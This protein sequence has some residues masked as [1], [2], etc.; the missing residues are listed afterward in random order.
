MTWLSSRWKI[1]IMVIPALVLFTAFIAYP[2]LYS[3]VFSFTRFNGFK[4]PV[5]NGGANY[6]SLFQDSYF[7]RS[8]GNTAIIFAITLVVLIPLAFLLALLMQ[9]RIPGAGGLRALVFAPAIIAPILSG[10]IWIF[11][12]DPHVGLLNQVLGALNLPRPE[13]IGGT[14]LTPFSVAWVYVWSQL[15]FA[16]TIFYAGLQLVP[17]D[18]LE[19]SELDGANGVKR[20]WYVIIPMIRETF[21]IITVLMITGVFKVFEIVYVLTGGGPT[22]TSET[23]VSYVYFLTFTSQRYGLGMAGA[24]IVTILGMVVGL[25]Y[26]VVA[27]RRQ[28]A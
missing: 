1:A 15:G 23:L 10:L 17:S 28:S 4:P 26:L 24:V 14:T 7:W 5:F 19:A 11:I 16:M 18:I 8:L 2:V 21:I 6:A 25:A 22:H 9:R 20:V 12:L 27:R 13:W 3:L